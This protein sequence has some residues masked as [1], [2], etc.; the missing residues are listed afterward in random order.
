M[1]YS[2]VSSTARLYSALWWTYL[3]DAQVISLMLPTLLPLS[4]PPH[5]LILLLFFIT[6]K[7][8]IKVK[9]K[10]RHVQSITHLD[11]GRIVNL[12]NSKT[13]Y[14]TSL[15]LIFFTKIGKHIQSFELLRGSILCTKI[16]WVLHDLVFA[17]V[18]AHNNSNSDIT[19]D[20]NR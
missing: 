20:R 3:W 12:I 9:R 13:K 11:S 7:D 1:Q 17:N 18:K 5:T 14:T 16:Y 4:K 10:K 2:K 8:S 15:S 6:S 19:A